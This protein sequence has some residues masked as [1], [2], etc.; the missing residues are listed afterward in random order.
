MPDRAIVDRAGAGGGRRAA[1][2]APRYRF[3]L[4]LRR[5]DGS[6][7]AQ[8]PAEVDWEPALA[9]ARW[10]SIRRGRRP[11]L[12][13]ASLRPLWHDSLGEPYLR[14]FSIA[15]GDGDGDE[16]PHEFPIRY[17]GEQALRA[18]LELVAQGK[19]E[20]SEPF[21]YLVLAFPAPDAPREAPSARFVVEEAEP[22]LTLLDSRLAS[23]LAAAEAPG[24]AAGAPVTEGA[25]GAARSSPAADA[26][27]FVPRSVLDEARA[28]S[29]EA[30]ARET[31]GVL[32][33]HLRHD[34]GVPESFVEVTAL[35]AA[36]HTQAEVDRLTFTAESWA[37]ARGVL[38]L[39]GRDELMLGWF[40]SHPVRHWCRECPIE[41]QR[42]CRLAHDYFS[43]HDRALH[44][45]VFPAA[46]SVALVVNVVGFGEETISM[47][48]WREGRIEP[49]EFHVIG[50]PS[51]TAAGPRPLPRSSAA[52]APAAAG[53]RH[54]A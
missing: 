9:W 35:I 36:Q 38:A 4:D 18:S 43:E 44:R 39:R 10:L 31:G 27:L 5:D 19:L 25:S 8:V 51:A 17:F 54:D 45:A 41:A 40:H 28:L 6:R 13:G 42:Q 11:T 23:F 46:W 14:G 26:P 15:P 3:A 52:A 20:K 32:V 1:P 47:F 34:A 12:A 48:G 53:G 29:R 16:A 21:K 22:A 30:G 33:G 24:A 37:A 49:R 50:A 2:L 7:L